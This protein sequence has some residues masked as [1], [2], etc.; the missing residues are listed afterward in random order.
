MKD[1]VSG[2]TME[3]WTTEPCI[4]TC[5]A[6]NASE[7]LSAKTPGRTLCKCCRLAAAASPMCTTFRAGKS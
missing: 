3:I 4:Q 5:G 6:Q 2:L 7:A 1:P